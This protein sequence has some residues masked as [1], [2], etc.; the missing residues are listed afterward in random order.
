ML[1]RVTPAGLKLMKAGQAVVEGV[2]TRSFASLSESE[3]D[4]LLALLTRVLADPLSNGPDSFDVPPPP[5]FDAPAP[6]SV[7]APAPA[8]PKRKPAR[9]R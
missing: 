3:R 4:V 9:A 5:S 2:I 8:S 6:P 7:E 1:H